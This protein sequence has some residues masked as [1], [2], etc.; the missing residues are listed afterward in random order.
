MKQ[1]ST[2][3][4]YT[5]SKKSSCETLYILNP[6]CEDNGIKIDVV[7]CKQYEKKTDKNS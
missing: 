4:C 6:M 3:L 7:R 2:D 5:C 1:S